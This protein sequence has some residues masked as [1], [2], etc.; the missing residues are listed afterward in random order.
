MQLCAIIDHM[1]A[2]NLQVTA[3]WP[4]EGGGGGGVWT[5]KIYPFLAISRQWISSQSKVL[6][7]GLEL[8]KMVCKSNNHNCQPYGLILLLDC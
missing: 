3:L 2:Q 5:Q 6:N 1:F 4:G 8:L 7:L